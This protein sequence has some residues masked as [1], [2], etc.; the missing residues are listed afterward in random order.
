MPGGPLLLR[1]GNEQIPLGFVLR[2]TNFERQLNPG[3]EGDA[4][5]ASV[6]QLV[7]EEGE[8]DESREISMNQP[9]SHRRFTIYQSGFDESGHGRETS[10]FSVAYDPGRPLKYA[11][12]LMI[13][14]GIGIM[15]YMR[16]Y[17]FKRAHTDKS[18]TATPDAQRPARVLPLS[19]ANERQPLRAA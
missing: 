6:V 8:I 9:L 5:F 1:Y 4:A 11:G 13:C 18:P 2:L 7:D 3:R 15:F 14:A 17:F 10:L 12:S 16:A 19:D